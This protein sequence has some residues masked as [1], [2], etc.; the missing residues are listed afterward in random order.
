MQVPHATKVI[1]RMVECLYWFNQTLQID[2]GQLTPICGNVK[3]AIIQNGGLSS[4]NYVYKQNQSC[5]RY[6]SKR[7]RWHNNC[8]I[9]KIQYHT[10]TES[11]LGVAEQRNSGQHFHEGW[12]CLWSGCAPP[13]L[14]DTYLCNV[15]DTDHSVNKT[16]YCF[17][18]LAV[19]IYK[20]RL[21]SIFCGI[22]RADLFANINIILHFGCWC[23][24]VLSCSHQT[25]Q[26]RTKI[27]KV[28]STNNSVVC[29][30]DWRILIRISCVHAESLSFY[31]FFLCVQ[32]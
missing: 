2:L 21:C 11:K 18:F 9:H 14:Y 10:I 15:V 30:F 17:I 27:A 12:V 24:A 19:T 26:Q 31:S 4:L 6:P 1:I 7:M 28:Q 3:C 5:P 20:K 22:Y 23:A 29:L 16:I 32:Q 8:N 13:L 25:I